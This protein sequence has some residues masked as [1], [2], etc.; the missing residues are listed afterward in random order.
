VPVARCLKAG[1]DLIT[2]HELEEQVLL[3]VHKGVIVS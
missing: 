1:G 2:E 3:Q